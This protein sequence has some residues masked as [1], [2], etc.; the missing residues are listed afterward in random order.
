MRCAAGIAKYRCLHSPG[1]HNTVSHQFG[2]ENHDYIVTLTVTNARGT[3]F[4]QK[5]VHTQG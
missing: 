5:L 2:L 4:I 1:H 3:A